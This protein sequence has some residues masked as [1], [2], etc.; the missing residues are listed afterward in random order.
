MKLVKSEKKDSVRFKFPYDQNIL[1][2]VRSLN[3]RKY[4]PDTKTWV[5]KVGFENCAELNKTISK[6]SFIVENSAKSLINSFFFKIEEEV[7]LKESLSGQTLEIPSTI[8]ATLR[9]YQKEG[10]TFTVVNRKCINGSE[11]G[12][13]KTLMTICALE[14]SKDYKAIIIVPASLKYNWQNEFTKFAPNRLVQVL[15]SKTLIDTENDVFIINYDI[16]ER[17]LNDLMNLNAKSL[18]CDES[19][20]IKNKSAKRSKAVKKLSKSIQRVCLLSGT[21]I[22]NRPSELINQIETIDQLHALGGY[23]TFI[24]RY[25]N[26]SRSRFGFDISGATNVDELFHKMS[27]SFYFRRNKVDVAKDLPEKTRISLDVEIDNYKEYLYAESN[28]TEFLK[29]RALEKGATAQEIAMI[30]QKVSSAEQLISLSVLRQL[31]LKGKIPIAIDWIENFLET[32]DGKLV[33]FCSFREGI[34]RL[35]EKFGCFHIDGS[36]DNRKRQD[37]VDAFQNDPKVRLIV[38]QIKSGGVGITL[39][40]A[41][42]GLFLE[43]DWSPADKQQ[44]EARIHRI[45]SENNVFLYKL[46][47]KNTIDETMSEIIENKEKVIDAINAGISIDEQDNKSIVQE[48]WDK[49]Y[50]K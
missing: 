4:D 28:L 43:E 22:K 7:K 46:V 36:V 40:A 21:M 35:V 31:T 16:V 37:Y 49:I 38:L 39:T 26:A 27:N 32:N 19:Q 8:K 15:D 44:A 2:D 20:N 11:A 45:G 47:A 23:W 48:V 12:L 1:N 34:N 42:T 5:V 14:Y 9:P 10:F 50:K 13:G 25:C 3:G 33:V 29:Q 41:S 6:H 30:D 17:R 18:V 24:N